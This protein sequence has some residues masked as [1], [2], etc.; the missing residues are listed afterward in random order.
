VDAGL[1]TEQLDGIVA[2]GG[3]TLTPSTPNPTARRVK[4]NLIGGMQAFDGF[5]GLEGS[6]ALGNETDLT[7][8]RRDLQKRNIYTGWVEAF[9]FLNSDLSLTSSLLH[10]FDLPSFVLEAFAGLEV[11]VDLLSKLN[12]EQYETALTY[13]QLGVPA[14]TDSSLTVSIATQFWPA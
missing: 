9:F 5:S 7:F 8:E 14:Y 6:S 3:Y 1:P 2:L 12:I 4:R 13:S 10:S 11:G